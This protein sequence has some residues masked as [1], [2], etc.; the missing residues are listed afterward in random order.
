[1]RD[2]QRWRAI[3]LVTFGVS[4][5]L[6]L[7]MGGAII[8]APVTIPLMYIAASKNP[9]QGFRV[10]ATALSALTTAEAVWAATYLAVDEAQPWIWLLPSAGALAVVA[11]SR[12]TC[13]G[14]RV[15]NDVR[16]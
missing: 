4:G 2:I 5:F 8:A 9:K 16:A 12:R 13:P 14:R 11:V 3:G 10:A 7:S 6:L 1:M 15:A